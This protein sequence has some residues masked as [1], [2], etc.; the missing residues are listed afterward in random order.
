MQFQAD[1]LGTEVIRPQVTETTAFG[2]ACFAGL[3]VGFWR[4]IDELKSHIAAGRSFLPSMDAETLAA[5][6]RGW[7]DA[8]SR[9]L[10]RQ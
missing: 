1:V 7:A 4:S 8:V 10:S 6:K 2:A 5:A 9:T 3:A